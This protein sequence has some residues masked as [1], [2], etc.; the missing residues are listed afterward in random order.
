MHRGWSGM[1]P[2]WLLVAS[3][4]V[5]ALTALSLPRRP[6]TGVM[7]APDR[8]AGVVPGSPG[9]RAGLVAG[10]RLRP[11]HP[12][13]GSGAVLLGPLAD[14]TPDT[15]LLLE[16]RPPLLTD[17]WFGFSRD[18]LFLRLDSARPL[19][20]LLDEGYEVTL[21]F[22]KPDGLKLLIS[23]RR[24]DP[25]RIER[26]AAATILEA[27]IPLAGLNA[28]LGVSFF[29]AIH[30]AQGLEVERHP[31]SHPFDVPAVDEAFEARHWTA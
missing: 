22:L 2:A 28:A 23:E 21:N 5:L 27:A 11:A 18:H 13:R 20:E 25:A 26:V 15:P 10:D 6:Y 30:D 4:F 1:I 3:A 8:V 9:H 24:V 17:V 29:V 16:R 7:W 31:A 19:K 12:P 14:A